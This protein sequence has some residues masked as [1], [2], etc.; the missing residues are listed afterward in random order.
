MNIKMRHLRGI[1]ARS[2]NTGRRRGRPQR[3]SL[4]GRA[5]PDGPEQ[6]GVWG[7]RHCGQGSLCLRLGRITVTIFIRNA[8]G[9]H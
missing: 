5:G 8:Q 4:P 3:D 1:P 9:R 7:R 6:G 2:A